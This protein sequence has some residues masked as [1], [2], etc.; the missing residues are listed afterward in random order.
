MRSRLLAG[1]VLVLSAAVAWLAVLVTVAARV[2][3]GVIVLSI[4]YVSYL[5]WEGWRTI[6]RARS[7][8][9][10]EDGE[11]LDRPWV[12]VVVPARDE[13]IGRA[14]CRERV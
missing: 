9:A 10:G 8:A 4:V 7:A 11:P 13:E 14:S 3:Q 12:T 6:R 1:G 5:A 2:L